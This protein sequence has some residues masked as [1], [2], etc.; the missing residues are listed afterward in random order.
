MFFIKRL[1]KVFWR[2]CDW[3]TCFL[4]VFYHW[5]KHQVSSLREGCD[6]SISTWM[7]Q[8]HHLK[9]FFQ[10]SK[11]P[12]STQVLSIFWGKASLMIDTVVKML[13]DSL[14]CHSHR[15]R[16]NTQLHLFAWHHWRM[17]LDF[18]AGLWDIAE[19][20]SLHH[21]WHESHLIPRWVFWM[22]N[23]VKA[24]FI[25]V[26]L[27]STSGNAFIWR[28]CWPAVFGLSSHITGISSSMF[29]CL[30]RKRMFV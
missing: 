6:S 30:I 23:G 28:V 3:V 7:S 2:E 22:L 5:D 18:P 20:E 10:S 19:Q 26:N 29:W 12:I 8:Q 14:E 15:L 16:K 13:S 27:K 9:C 21:H 24:L 17:N 11:L 25:V 4:E 1:P